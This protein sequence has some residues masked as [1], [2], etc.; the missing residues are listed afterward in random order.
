MARYYIGRR[1]VLK[2]FLSRQVVKYKSAIEKKKKRK[3]GLSIFL[4]Y[5]APVQLADLFFFFLSY[6]TIRTVGSGSF[7]F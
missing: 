6:V 1:V 2:K 7:K 5:K 3:M 4:K